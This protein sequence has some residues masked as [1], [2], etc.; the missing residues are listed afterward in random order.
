MSIEYEIRNIFLEKS[1]RKCAPKAHSKP[2]FN[3]GKTPK[4]PLHGR[5]S[6]KNK[7]I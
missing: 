2:L 6:F 4:K 7:I 3:F 5:N 1:W